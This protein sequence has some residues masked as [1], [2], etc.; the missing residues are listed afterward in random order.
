M[1]SKAIVRTR[2]R[3]V[4]RTR[5]GAVRG[6][7]RKIPIGIIAGIVPGLAWSWRSKEPYGLFQTMIYAYT[8]F[9][10]WVGWKWDP[11]AMKNGGYQLLAGLAAHYAAQKFGINRMLRGVPWVEI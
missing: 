7:T 3:T 1:A 5:R 4:V 11:N 2:T 6:G 8:G 9:C 10:P